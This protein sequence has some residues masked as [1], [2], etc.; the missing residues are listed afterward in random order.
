[1]SNE[2]ERK[3][4]LG[5]LKEALTVFG[6]TLRY[7]KIRI[8]NRPWT[9]LQK[10]NMTMAPNGNV[11]FQPHAYHSDFSVSKS[12]MAH[13]IHELTHVQQYQSGESPVIGYIKNSKY[14]YGDLSKA[15]DYRSFGT[16]QR[17]S[18]SEDYYRVLNG[19]P[20]TEGTGSRADFE[21]IVPFIPKRRR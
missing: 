10:K 12:A 21:R 13:L 1:M 14:K 6:R 2:I 3:L 9:R 4:T 8:F 5:E 15:T 18:I 17:A 16:E 19:M 20:L 7:D 11:Y